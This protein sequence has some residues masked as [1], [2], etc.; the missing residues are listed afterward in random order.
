MPQSPWLSRLQAPCMLPE[1]REPPVYSVK[2]NFCGL[3]QLCLSSE[4]TL[5]LSFLL[6]QTGLLWELRDNTLKD[7]AQSSQVPTLELEIWFCPISTGQSHD[8][9][10][11]RGNR[12]L[13]GYYWLQ[14]TE[15]C[16][17][18]WLCSAYPMQDLVENRPSPR[19]SGLDRLDPNLRGGWHQKQGWLLPSLSRGYG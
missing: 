13:Q 7:L 18:V 5:G 19:D 9:L 3:P 8:L 16:G 2:G 17:S 6:Y 1:S 15:W 12:E 4:P 11:R 10:F 14:L